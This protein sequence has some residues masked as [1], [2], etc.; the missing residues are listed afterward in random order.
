MAK[1]QE[2]HY[3]TAYQLARSGLTE[4]RIA[5][6]LGISQ[7]TLIAWKASRPAFADAIARGQRDGQGPGGDKLDFAQYVFQHLPPDLQDLWETLEVAHLHPNGAA[8]VA[9]LMDK[10]GQRVRQHIL[11]YALTH[12][13]FNMSAALRQCAIPKRTLDNWCQQDPDFAA[14]LDEIHWHKKNFFENQLLALV[15]T[16]DS[17]AVIFANKTFNRDRGYNERV[18]VDVTGSVDI[19]HQQVPLDSL[20]L[21]LDARRAILA[22]VQAATTPKLLAAP[23]AKPDDAAP[24]D[25]IEGEFV[26]NPLT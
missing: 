3:V 20:N 17:P 8:R 13:N 9:A 22:A 2:S 7:P 26:V 10:Q 25:A 11:V 15:A 5:G 1:W 24:A 19:A 16:G 23:D 6:A 18:E 4:H 14:L 12:C 21:S